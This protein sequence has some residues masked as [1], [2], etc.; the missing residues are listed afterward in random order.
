MGQ[1]VMCHHTVIDLG[2]E[3]LNGVFYPLRFQSGSLCEFEFVRRLEDSFIPITKAS[4]GFLE[5]GLLQ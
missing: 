5:V 1:E 2:H 4:E 3:I